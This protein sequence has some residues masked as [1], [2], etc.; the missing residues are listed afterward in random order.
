L[1]KRKTKWAKKFKPE[2][3][4]GDPLKYNVATAAKYHKK[5]EKLIDLMSKEVNRELTKLYKTE[6]AKA[7]F[8][9]DASIA[10]MARILMNALSDRFT[11]LFITM[12]GDMAA[13]FIDGVDKQSKSTLF[14][15]METMTGGARIKTDI[16]SGDLSETIK[17]SIAENVN[18]IRSIPEQYFTSITGQVMR[19]VTSGQ[20]LKDLL[21][22]IEKHDMITKKR[23]KIIAY[24]QTRK[25]YSSI[26]AARM[27]KVGVKKFMWHHSAGGLHP[28]EDHIAMDGNIY[29]FDD[30]PIVNK[31]TGE[32]GLPGSQINCRCFLSPIIEFDDGEIVS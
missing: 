7:Y 17:A 27:Q 9:E 16:M 12:S 26:N 8:A 3:L 22:F 5:I 6:T 20:G 21:P 10:S 32:R 4:K 25:A 1:T 15:S 31:K 2:V 11:S 13:S 19:S 30:L 14:S 24:D 28:R 29:S 18:L 23:A